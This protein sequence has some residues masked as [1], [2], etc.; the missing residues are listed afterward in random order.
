MEKATKKRGFTL[1][2][3]IVVLVILAVLAALL[4]PALT[5]YIDKA[6]KSQVIAETRILHTAIQTEMSEL[7]AKPEWKVLGSFSPV[8]E[9]VHSGNEPLWK[10]DTYNEIVSLS[11]VPSLQ[12]GGDGRFGGYVS[13]SGKVAFL[14]YYDGKGHVGIYFA[15][16]QEYIALDV[17]EAPNYKGYLLND[18]IELNNEFRDLPSVDKDSLFTKEKLMLLITG[19]VS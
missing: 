3:L 5:G 13:P 15:E 8:A 14:L 18:K 10:V 16:T 9:K 17:D 1:V 11:E 12:N 2:E 4:V 19:K 7:Y 6:K